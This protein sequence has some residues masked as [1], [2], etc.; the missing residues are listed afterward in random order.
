MK[1]R[2]FLAASSALAAA[3]ALPVSA[4]AAA[5]ANALTQP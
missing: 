3:Q 4:L 1:R 2:T 5:P